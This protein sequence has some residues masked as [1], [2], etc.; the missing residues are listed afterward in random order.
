MAKTNTQTSSTE[1]PR[2]Y[3]TGDRV[4]WVIVAVLVVFSVLVV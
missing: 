4:L 3:L 1:A 2:R